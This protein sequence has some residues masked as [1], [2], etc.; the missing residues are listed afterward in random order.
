MWCFVLLVCGGVLVCYFFGC[1]CDGVLFFLFCCSLFVVFV[2]FVL[3]LGGYCILF[4]RGVVGWFFLFV[5]VLLGCVVLLGFFL[6]VFVV[7]VCGRL[8]V[9]FVGVLYFVLCCGFMCLGVFLFVGLVFVC[10]CCLFFGCFGFLLYWVVFVCYVCRVG[11]FF[12]LVVFC[13]W[14]GVVFNCVC[15]FSHS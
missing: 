7:V 9:F 5:W 3:G 12:F 6:G 4:G 8:L 14:G 11:I 2:G 1:F 10:G 13:F 15:F